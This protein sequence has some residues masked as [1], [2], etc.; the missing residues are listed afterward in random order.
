MSR[1]SVDITAVEFQ[2]KLARKNLLDFLELA[3]G[4][5]KNWSAIRRAVLKVFG[6]DGLEALLIME[7]DVHTVDEERNG[8]RTRNFRYTNRCD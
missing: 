4:N 8:D 3:C 2:I 1:N 7:G 5:Q 6:R